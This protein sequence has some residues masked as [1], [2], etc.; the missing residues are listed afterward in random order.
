MTEQPNLIYIKKLSGEDKAFEEKFIAIIKAEFPLEFREYLGYVR[1]RRYKETSE[2]VH[3]LKHKLNILGLEK[4]YRLAVQYEEDLL[5]A[6]TRLEQEF[7]LILKN[8]EDF[9]KNI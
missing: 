8:I 9:I 4:S 7:N 1:D 3:K 5:N 6:D 2:I